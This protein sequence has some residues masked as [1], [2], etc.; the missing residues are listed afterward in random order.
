MKAG[1]NVTQDLR[2]LEKECN[3]PVK[4]TGAVELAPMAKERNVIDNARRGL[5][6]ICAAVL[7]MRLDKFDSARLHSDWSATTLSENQVNYATKDAYA[8]LQIYHAL[9][10]ITVPTAILDTALPGTPV[11]ILHDDGKIIAHGILSQAPET[12]Q[13]HSINH[14]KT[15]ARVTVNDIL[16]PAAIVPLHNKS[17]QSFGLTPFDILVKHSKLQSHTIT[18]TPPFTN[19]ATSNTPDQGP[20]LDEDVSNFLS[21]PLSAGESDWSDGVDDPPDPD[22]D[23]DIPIGTHVDEAVL[24]KAIKSLPKTPSIWLKHVRSRVLMDIW[25]A[26]ARIKLSKN[27]GFACPFAQTLRD[28]I[29]IPDED[30]KAQIVAYLVTINSSWD[31]MLRFNAKWLWRHCKQIV[32]PPEDLF[33]AV[34][35]IYK[36]FG[37]LHDAATNTPLFND[38]AWKDAANILKAIKSGLLSDP[39]DVPLYYRVGIDKKHGNLPI[40]GCARGTNNAEG[41]VHHSGQ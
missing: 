37:P 17:L 31:E 19:S 20:E 7:H 2:R 35:E 34:H 30:D 33:P 14:T 18:D 12:S 24:Q 39:L 21:H 22:D 3:S 10:T 6:D 15:R 25:H 40:Y 5:A 36:T 41:G 32:P 4:F 28:A 26:M 27:H 38:R 29:F 16:V 11:S 13:L 1:R 9:S 23:P 8:S